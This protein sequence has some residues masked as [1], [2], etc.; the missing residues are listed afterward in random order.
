MRA[1]PQPI[2]TAAQAAEAKWGIPA[3]VTIA[4]WAVESA[5]GQHMPPGSNNPFGIKALPG[6]PAVTVPTHEVIQGKTVAI[7]ARFRRFATLDDAFDWH[8]QLLAHGEPYAKARRVVGKPSAFANALTGVYATDPNYGRTLNAVMK[9]NNLTQY[10]RP[11]PI[12]VVG[13]TP[14]IVA[15][16]APALALSYH[17]SAVFPIV[18]A[19]LAA[20][21][22]AGLTLTILRSRK[23]KMPT[24]QQFQDALTNLLAAKDAQAAKAVTDATAPLNAKISE[25][26]ATPPVTDTGPQVDTDDTAA[27]VAATPAA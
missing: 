13:L 27:L 15:T 20:L 1:V 19:L 24:S 9:A 17:H 2:I 16:A 25:L 12:P 4:Q 11:K 21:S 14:V 6:Q 5:W 8:G 18:V 22:I 3:S 7:F 26:E 23:P 10:D